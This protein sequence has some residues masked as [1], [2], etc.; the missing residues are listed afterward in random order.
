MNKQSKIISILLMFFLL[1]SGC[2]D[3]G[4]AVRDTAD[5]VRRVSFGP[6]AGDGA[7]NDANFYY[8][9]D[10]DYN[11]NQQQYG[12]YPY[13]PNGKLNDEQYRRNRNYNNR[14]ENQKRTQNNRNTTN[15][16]RENVNDQS[17]NEFVREVVRLTNE[18]RQSRGLSP[19]TMDVDLNKAAQAKSKD[20]ATEGYFSHQ[21]PTY[22]SPFDMLKSFGIDYRVAAENIAAGQNTPEDVVRVWMNSEGHRANIL[23]EQLTHIGVG[24]HKGG[25][26]NHYWTQLFIAK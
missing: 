9:W 15:E 11:E 23:N 13:E 21:S 25:S 14:E 10:P 5:D 6:G 8:E 19:L 7:D 24:Y 22:G 4:D 20:M 17:V 16:N 12:N 26:M 1:L 18:E 3:A 2:N